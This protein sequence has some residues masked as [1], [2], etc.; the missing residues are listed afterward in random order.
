MLG[1]VII[2]A[3]FIAF[4]LVTSA[5]ATSDAQLFWNR[6]RQAVLSGDSAS[7]ATMTKLPLW[8]RGPDDN[9]PVMY[10][11]GQDLDR[12]LR[13]L[14]NQEVSILQAGKITT[15]SMREVIKEKTTLSPKD[16]QVP[17]SLSVELLYFEKVAGKWFLTRGYLEDGSY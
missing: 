8:V 4:A 2:I 15:R 9:D 5:E 1:R 7:V 12:V 14:L 3:Y 11:G 17:N 10:Y 16:L 13:R 6:F